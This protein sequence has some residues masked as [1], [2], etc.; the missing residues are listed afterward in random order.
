MFQKLVTNE[1][2]CSKEATEIRAYIFDPMQ[3]GFIFVRCI[4]F[5]VAACTESRKNNV[6]ASIK[7]CVIFSETNA[8]S[9]KPLQHSQEP[10]V[11]IKEGAN[12][13]TSH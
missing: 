4:L 10:T 12:G 7:T 6:P 1:D 8:F 9:L 3:W 2:L 11:A 13:E 5:C